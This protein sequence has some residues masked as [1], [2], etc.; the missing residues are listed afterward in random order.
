MPTKPVSGL[1]NGNISD[2][3][4]SNGVVTAHRE[5]DPYGNTTAAT[6]AMVNDFHFW[7]SSKYLDAETGLYYYGYR[8]YSPEMGRWIAPDPI[9][10]TYGLNIFPFV[11]NSPIEQVD[12]LGLLS[13]N[14]WPNGKVQDADSNWPNAGADGIPGYELYVQFSDPAY[15][16]GIVVQKV[17]MDIEWI[18]LNDSSC[19]KLKAHF[20]YGEWFRLD[21]GKTPIT[22][23]NARK[24]DG[25]LKRGRVDWHSVEIA[26]AGW[27]K[28]KYIFTYDIGG[29]GGPSA[30]GLGFGMCKNLGTQY[31]PRYQ[32]DERWNCAMLGSGKTHIEEYEFNEGNFCG[33]KDKTDC[34]RI[35]Q[36]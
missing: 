28:S 35:S 20:E 33:C 5:F 26:I 31:P 19:T 30:S 1:P 32:N 34:V 36:P 9:N 12:Y 21:G 29:I 23:I 4:T 17:V 2:Y 14:L 22:P 7:F 8:Y 3:L 24:T 10:E 15:Q 16:N 27:M 13:M 25:T 11:L 18:K 6:G